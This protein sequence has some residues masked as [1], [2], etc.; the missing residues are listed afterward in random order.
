[1]IESRDAGNLLDI[2][3]C[4]LRVHRRLILGGFTDQ[5]LLIGEGD[6]GRSGIASLLVGN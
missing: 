6:E 3:D 5:A 4:V 1:M 2:K